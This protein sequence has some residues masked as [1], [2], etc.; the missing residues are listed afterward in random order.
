MV[1][2]PEYFKDI[3]EKN[4]WGPKELDFCYA[5][6]RRLFIGIRTPL[7]TDCVLYDFWDIK[8]NR[9]RYPEHFNMIGVNMSPLFGRT[10][11]RE[12]R[13]KQQCQIVYSVD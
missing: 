13:N 7:P 2:N 10:D 4:S 9:H 8:Q 6:F 3:P 11:R 5:F 1:S 12:F